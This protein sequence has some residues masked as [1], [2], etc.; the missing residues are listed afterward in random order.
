MNIFQCNND[1][2]IARVVGVRMATQAQIP[3]VPNT[4]DLWFATD[5]GNFSI[6]SSGAQ[7]VVGSSSGST[8]GGVF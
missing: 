7:Q 8:D 3:V 1:A 2:G 4:G 6:G 5:T